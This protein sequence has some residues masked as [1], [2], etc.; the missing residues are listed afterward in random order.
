VVTRHQG[1][2]WF[3]SEEGRGTTFFIR[4]PLEVC[5]SVP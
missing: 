5:P 3:E 1:E 4:L 2:I